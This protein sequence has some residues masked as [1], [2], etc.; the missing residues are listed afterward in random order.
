MKPLYEIHVVLR[1]AMDVMEDT[2]DIR[3]GPEVS[4]PVTNRIHASVYSAVIVALRGR[5]HK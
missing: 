4:V 5:G 3:V 2:Y 1:V